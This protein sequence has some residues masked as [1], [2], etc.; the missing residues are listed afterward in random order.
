MAAMRPAIVPL[1]VG[2]IDDGVNVSMKT[3]QVFWFHQSRAVSSFRESLRASCF[4]AACGCG[5]DSQPW[6]WPYHRILEETRGF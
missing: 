5:L 2:D 4:I 6:G 1:S 3:L